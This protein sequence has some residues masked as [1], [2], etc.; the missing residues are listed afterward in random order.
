MFEQRRNQNCGRRCQTDCPVCREMIAQVCDAIV[1]AEDLSKSAGRS[2]PLLMARAQAALERRSAEH[3]LEA[4]IAAQ[5]PPELS[6]AEAL[7]QAGEK[8]LAA[9]A[10]ESD[11]AR[12]H[13]ARPEDRLALEHWRKLH[14]EAKKLEGRYMELTGQQ[15]FEPGGDWAARPAAAPVAGRGRA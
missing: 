5:H 12:I 2:L 7:I 13:A 15:T 9:L 3:R 4:H 11:A 8:L 1:R 10:A 14:Q 6:P